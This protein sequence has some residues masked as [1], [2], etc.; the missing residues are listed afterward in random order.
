MFQNLLAYIIIPEQELI[1]KIAVC[2]DNPSDLSVLKGE[3]EKYFSSRSIGGSSVFYYC[4]RSGEE[5]LD[6]AG[7][8][9]YDLVLLDIYMEF[10]DGMEVARRIRMENRSVPIV[11]TTNSDDHAMEGY[12]VGAAGYLMKPV[13]STKLCSVLD[14]IFSAALGDGTVRFFCRR[15]KVELDMSGILFIESMGRSLL[16]HCAGG[17]V[18]RVN[19]KLD[20]VEKRM[21]NPDFLRCH[22]SYLVNMSHI[23]SACGSCFLLPAGIRVPVRQRDA[24]YLVRCYER[25]VRLKKPGS[26]V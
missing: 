4:F 26:G 13:S 24:A 16:V 3:L 1:L 22:K 12:E 23:V 25:F 10:M 21:G 9:K 19:E 20:D 17:E 8:F 14:R 15:R 5:L 11:F 7:G 18:Y 6:A 2:E